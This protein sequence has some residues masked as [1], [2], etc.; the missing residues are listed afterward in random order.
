MTKHLKIGSCAIWRGTNAKNT[1]AGTVVRIVAR[2]R[3]G[4]RAINETIARAKNHPLER[5]QQ[6][7]RRVWGR[8]TEFDPTSCK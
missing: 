5:A 2:T 1:P 4:Y 3:Y 8:P 7:N 6:M